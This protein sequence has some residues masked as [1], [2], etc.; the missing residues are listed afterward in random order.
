MVENFLLLELFLSPVMRPHKLNKCILHCL[1][2]A[3]LYRIHIRHDLVNNFTI[4]NK[5]FISFDYNCNP[6]LIWP[7]THTVRR[8]TRIKLNSAKQITIFYDY[9]RLFCRMQIF[10]S[11]RLNSITFHKITTLC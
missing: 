11:C 1:R 5:K 8:K 9:F 10:Q 7:V 6:N 4:I 2:S 3:F